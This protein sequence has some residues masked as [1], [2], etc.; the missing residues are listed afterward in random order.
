MGG[1]MERM[2]E[3]QK[4]LAFLLKILPVRATALPQPCQHL[5]RRVLPS[6][7]GRRL[8]KKR[9]TSK[10]AKAEYLQTGLSCTCSKEAGLGQVQAPEDSTGRLFDSL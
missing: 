6:H 5:L 7:L 9:F 2:L 1:E 3:G 10:A 4:L 8:S